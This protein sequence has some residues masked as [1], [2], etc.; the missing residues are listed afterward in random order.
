MVTQP[1]QQREGDGDAGRGDAGCLFLPMGIRA[2]GLGHLFKAYFCSILITKVRF[3]H[4]TFEFF[5]KC[6][7]FKGPLVNTLAKIFV[8]SV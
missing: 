3:V 2:T 1:K 6:R 5:F 8:F 7:K 4:R